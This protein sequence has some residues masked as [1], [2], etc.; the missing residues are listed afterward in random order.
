M[1]GVFLSKGLFPSEFFQ[2]TIDF[3]L[4]CQ[5]ADGSIPWFEGSYADPWDHTEAAM[6]LSIGGEWDAAAK[7]YQWLADT[8]L[9]DGSW[10]AAYKA[11][12]ID[13]GERR[14]SNFVAYIATGVWHHYLITHNK[15]FLKSMW[16]MVERA[17]EFVLSL[18]S[19]HGEIQ[20]AV[21]P[22]GSPKM[23]ALITG[24][25]SIYKSLECAIN[26]AVTMGEDSAE[27]VAARERLGD[28]LRNKPERFD[29]TWES[30]ARYSMDWFYP[31]L[32]GVLSQPQS[33]ARLKERWDEFVEENLGCRCVSD[34]P[35]VTVAESCEL[36][37]ALLAAGDHARAVNVYSWLHQWRLEDGSY[38]TGYQFAQ[39]VLWPDEKPTWTAGAIILAADALTEYTPAA[40]L[41]TEVCLLNQEKQNLQAQ[42][43]LK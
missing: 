10:W 43:H 7:A 41:F 39:D 28:A 33:Q 2:P 22:N 27:W 14:E 26:I 25:S 38:W 9:D 32:T 21:K 30:K 19:E 23:D 11:G 6:A 40:K 8:Q 37:M 20:W 12:E 3:I 31:V 42:T 34:E 4:N 15:N 24:C 16:P 18:Q 17:I 35:W 13:N 1:S 5:Q 29:R 36:T